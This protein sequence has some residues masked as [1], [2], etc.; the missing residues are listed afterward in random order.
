[1]GSQPASECRQVLYSLVLRVQQVASI[2]F[3]VKSSWQCPVQ[4]QDGH[5]ESVSFP[6]TQQK[7]QQPTDEVLKAQADV[8]AAA[9]HQLSIQQTE[10]G[11]R[12]GHQTAL[13][14]LLHWVIWRRLFGLAAVSGAAAWAGHRW[15]GAKAWGSAAARRGLPASA[16][17]GEPGPSSRYQPQSSDYG[18]ARWVLWP[19]HYWSSSM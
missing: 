6:I 2:D 16:A 11:G 8:A 10:Q 15:L 19:P 3:A 4:E 13:A 1:M 5:A 7:D 9:L 18:T 14:S 17:A 12:T